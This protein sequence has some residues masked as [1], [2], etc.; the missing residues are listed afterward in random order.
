MAEVKK[1]NHRLF[2]VAKEFNVSIDTIVDHLKKK[3]HDVD[4]KPNTKLPG[5]LYN[6]LHKE[7][8]SEKQL[9][10]KAEQITK[11]GSN[12]DWPLQEEHARDR[13]RRG[14]GAT[15]PRPPHSL[16]GPQRLE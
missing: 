8:A 14:P 7:F 9:K 10:E 6:V 13:T 11:A 15:P 2:K 3:G 4:N 1:Q 12:H 16:H 5:E